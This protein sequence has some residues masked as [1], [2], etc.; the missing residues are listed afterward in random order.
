MKIWRQKD[1]ISAEKSLV[2]LVVA[3][4]LI[5]GF[6]SVSYADEVWAKIRYCTECHGASGR[7]YH[8]YFPI[9]RL[10]GQQPEY[11]LNQLRAF[12][13]RRRETDIGMDMALVHGL[14]PTIQKHVAAH[15]KDLEPPVIR[16][17][18]RG[19]AEAGKKIYEQGLPAS[20]V[21]ACAACHG[22]DAK[23][24]AEIPSL[25][26]QLFPYT[27]K[28]LSNWD[29]E[30]TGSASTTVMRIVAG[31]MTKSEIREVAAYVNSL[32]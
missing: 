8:G 17:A 14:S 4:I 11:I 18:P 25:S 31:N 1:L 27:V 28:E 6:S 19:L 24:G 16:D 9:P 32:R 12:A 26:G 2:W 20:N 15:F 13:E 7:G 21:P 29:R 5:A 22:G 3:A 23:G 10:A 30:R